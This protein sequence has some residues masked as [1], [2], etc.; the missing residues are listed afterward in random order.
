[1]TMDYDII[2]DWEKVIHPDCGKEY[3]VENDIIKFPFMTEEGCAKL[4]ALGTKT[5]SGVFT[6][7]PAVE[8][9]ISATV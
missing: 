7:S 4:V 5:L 8:A 6:V 2:A 3:H 1:M 9:S